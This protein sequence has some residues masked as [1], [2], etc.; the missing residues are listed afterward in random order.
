MTVDVVAVVLAMLSPLGAVPLT[1]HLPK[2]VPHT[3]VSL[4]WKLAQIFSVVWM[5]GPIPK[6]HTSAPQCPNCV[7]V[8]VAV[9]VV[10]VLVVVVVVAVVLAVAVVAVMVVLNKLNPSGHSSVAFNPVQ[11]LPSASENN[12]THGPLVPNAQ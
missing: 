2:F 8:V 1:V 5:H 7:V 3:S 4:F 11:M 6:S 10:L 9:V 12:L